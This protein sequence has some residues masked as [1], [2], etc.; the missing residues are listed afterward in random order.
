MA[1]PAANQY[2]ALSSLDFIYQ[3][4]MRTAARNGQRVEAIVALPEPEWFVA[5]VKSVLPHVAL[6]YTYTLVEPT[7][8]Q[9]L[10]YDSGMRVRNEQTKSEDR[11]AAPALPPVFFDTDPLMARLEQVILTPPGTTFSKDD[12]ARFMGYSGKHPWK[13]NK[14]RLT[15]LLE[16]F[17]HDVRSRKHS[18]RRK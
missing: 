14:E 13:E 18:V 2:F 3:A 8:E 12:A 4:I 9:V 15:H 10:E 5:L 11:Q 6:G 7:V 17:F 16:P 1:I